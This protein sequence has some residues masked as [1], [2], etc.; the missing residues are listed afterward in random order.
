MLLGNTFAAP[1]EGRV[2]L[3]DDATSQL[4]QMQTET[5]AGGAYQAIA[6]SGDDEFRHDRMQQADF[7]DVSIP[8]FTSPPYNAD[9]QVHLNDAAWRPGCEGGL[10]VGGSNTFGSTKG[11]VV[12]FTVDNGVACP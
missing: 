12:R 10:I 4:A 11:Y 1:I 5:F 9:A 2:Y 6:W 8:N 7:V 3:W